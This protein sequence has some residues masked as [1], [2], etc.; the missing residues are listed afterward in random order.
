MNVM[1]WVM[2]CVLLFLVGVVF[3]VVGI[4]VF[5]VGILVGGDLLVWM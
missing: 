1:N 2:N 4:V 5:V 3:F